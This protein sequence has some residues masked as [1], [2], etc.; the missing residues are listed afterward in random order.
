LNGIGLSIRQNI[1][2]DVSL[3]SAV[4]DAASNIWATIFATLVASDESPSTKKH[5]LFPHWIYQALG[6]SGEGT[7]GK[8]MVRR[9]L[10]FYAR[11]SDVERYEQ[12]KRSLSLYRLVFGQPRQQD[13]VERLIATFPQMNPT[14]IG[15]VF[16]KYTINLSPF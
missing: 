12:L 4:R 15:R 14:E 3:S 16:A 10:M 11:S 5:G 7:K 1:A 2:Q 8:E 6:E 13:I 9:H